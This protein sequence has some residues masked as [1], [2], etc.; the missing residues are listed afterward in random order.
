MVALFSIGV[1]ECPA[2][3]DLLTA[4]CVIR[5]RVVKDMRRHG[6]PQVLRSDGNMSWI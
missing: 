6:G 1:V 4:A 5:A 2:G 3:L